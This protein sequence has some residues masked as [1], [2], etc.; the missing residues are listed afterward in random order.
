MTQTS[1]LLN[2][3]ELLV[4][5]NDYATLK[6]LVR[7]CQEFGSQLDST[8]SLTS[9]NDF[10]KRRK[11]DGIIIDLQVPGALEFIGTIRKSNSN[12]TSILFACTAT[13]EEA[14]LA[15]KAGANFIAEKPCTLIQ[16]QELL[17]KAAPT[18]AEERKRY[19]RHKLVIPV[20]L[21]YDGVQHRA[22]TSNLS[23]TGM[24]IRSFRLFEPGIP[25]EFAFD[26]P[27]GPGVKGKGEIMWM[28]TEGHA[29]IKFDSLDCTG[30]PHIIEWLGHR[31]MVVS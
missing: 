10:L 5:S 2:N 18:L 20:T 9:A 1:A 13:P 29:G 21:F 11:I 23:E 28:D 15:K 7:A 3:L 27:S 8:P 30:T 25:V 6:M 31:R 16:I 24:A 12:R 19:F 17:T 14:E 22:L 4:V 26:L